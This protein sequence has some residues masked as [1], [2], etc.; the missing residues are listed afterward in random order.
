MIGL[1][2]LLTN[3]TTTIITGMRLKY[4]MA[5]GDGVITVIANAATNPVPPVLC[6]L[7]SA[8]RYSI[9]FIFAPEKS[10]LF[11]S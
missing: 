4:L 3:I 7:E 8:R 5:Y 11:E 1:L 6:T 10:V 2:L 9:N